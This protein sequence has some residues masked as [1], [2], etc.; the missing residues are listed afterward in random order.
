MNNLKNR[1]F[2]SLSPKK[3]KE[4]AAKGGAMA[5]KKGVAHCFSHNEAVKAGKK[6]KK[7]KSISLLSE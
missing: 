2:G 1:G 3:L 7:R 5:H 4:V 6:G